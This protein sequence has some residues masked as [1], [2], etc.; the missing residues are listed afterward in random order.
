MTLLA[1]LRIL[2]SPTTFHVISIND[3]R[4]H[5]Q[6]T[7]GSNFYYRFF[8]PSGIAQLQTA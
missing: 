2:I 6:R 7:R 5:I 4:H 1:I 8:P 3:R